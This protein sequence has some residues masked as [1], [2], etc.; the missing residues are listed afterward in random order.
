MKNT[1]KRLLTSVTTTAWK[2]LIVRF[3]VGVNER[4]QNFLFLVR[5]HL[6][7]KESLNY[8]FKDWNNATSLFL[9]N[10]R[11]FYCS[12]EA[13]RGGGG[14][15]LPV[16]TFTV[17]KRKP[18]KNSGFYGIR[19]L[20][21]CEFFSSPLFATAKVASITTMIFFHIIFHLVRHMKQSNFISSLS[22][23]FR[24]SS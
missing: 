9:I 14:K 12:R 5:L 16:T 19:T 6:A 1:P 15:L 3:I 18:E 8:H 22:S 11:S 7:K 23:Y 24:H 2:C 20:D 10:K 4:R 21:L 17:A 13:L